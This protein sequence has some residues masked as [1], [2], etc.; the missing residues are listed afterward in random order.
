L[1]RDGTIVVERRYLSSPDHAAGT[2][3]PDHIVDDLF[4]AATGIGR[5]LGKGCAACRG[6]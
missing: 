4:E 2:V 1:D 3:V 6:E 5:Q